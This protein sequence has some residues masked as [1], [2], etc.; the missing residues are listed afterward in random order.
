MHCVP[1]L[2]PASVCIAHCNA[3]CPQIVFCKHVQR[4]AAQFHPTPHCH[5]SQCAPPVSPQFTESAP[6]PEPLLLNGGQK[7]NLGFFAY[8]ACTAG[9]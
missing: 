7:S 2:S 6:V 8:T 5:P 9:Q 4:Q 1:K 3:L